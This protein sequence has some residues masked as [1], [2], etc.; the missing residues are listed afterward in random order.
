VTAFKRYVRLP[1][2]AR[3]ETEDELA[4]HIDMKVQELVQK[5]TR[6]EDAR[7][8]ALEQFGDR[9]Q[10]RSEVEQLVQA[11]RKRERRAGWF[12]A[13]RQDVRFALRQLRSTPGFTLVAV[14]TIGLGIGATTAIFSVVRAVLLRPLPYNAADRIVVIGETDSPSTADARTT[15]SYLTFEDWKARARSFESM[16]IFNGWAPVITGAGEAERLHGSLVTSDVFEVFGIRPALGR[17]MIPSD[18]LPNGPM[19]VWISWSVWQTRFGGASDVIGRL[20]VLNGRTRKSWAY[21]RA[22]LSRL[23]E[24]WPLTSGDR[25]P[26]MSAILEPRARRTWSRG[27][28]LG[29]HR[30]GARRDGWHHA[31]TGQGAPKGY[32]GEHAVVF[33][34]REL[35]IGSR[36]RGPILLLMLASALVLLIACANTSN[37]LIAR[38]TYRAKEF[39]IRAALGTTRARLVRQLLTESVVLGAAGA[40]LGLGLAALGVRGLVRLAPRVIQTQNVTVDPIV[41][42]FALICALLAA[43]V[44]G[45]L[46]ALRAGRRDVQ[47]VLR[48]VGRG[49]TSASASRVRA[50]LAIVQLSL[51]LSLVLSA[52]L[53]IKS[54]VRVL[55]VTPGIRPDHLLTVYLS[56]P[57]GKYDDSKVVPFSRS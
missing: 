3:S 53:L 50:G 17:R 13:A 27:S 55:Q 35:L 51:A 34:F 8:A 22:I 41:L 49:S 40:A 37:L 11:R 54:F 23:V 7:R 47:H 31:A 4:Y 30:S 21:C 32:T 19:I 16:A 46:P 25:I 12:D 42:G 9:E 14:L 33:P 29:E 2:N 39:A 57:G 18:N 1:G 20:L 28:R 44:F 48:E 52:G 56:L 38:G 26:T 6:P 15:T 24:S 10:I 45:L 43:M 36:T 5:G